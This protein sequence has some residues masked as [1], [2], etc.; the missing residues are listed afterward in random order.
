MISYCCKQKFLYR[1]KSFFIIN[2]T[3]NISE[4]LCNMVKILTFG[5]LCELHT[6]QVCFQ[7]Y[8]CFQRRRLKTGIVLF[9][10]TPLNLLFLLSNI[11]Q[12]QKNLLENHPITRFDI[13]R[14]VSEIIGVKGSKKGPAPKVIT[15]SF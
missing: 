15:L 5:L 9:V 13:T 3:R 2:M 4:T 14:V 8:Q 10:L 6:Y 7:V 1:L 12:Q 11:N